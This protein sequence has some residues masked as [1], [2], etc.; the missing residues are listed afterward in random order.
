MPAYDNTAVAAKLDLAAD[1]LELAGA[2]KFRVLSYRKAAR[3]VRACPEQVA[4]LAS[5][6]ALTG[7]EGV[8]AKM[9]THIEQVIARGSFDALDE[10]SQQL[11]P[12]LAEVMHVSGVGPTRALQLHQ[13]LGVSSLDDLEDA[14]VRGRVA[15]LGGFGA[16][17]SE[18]IAESLATHRRHR[19][20]TPLAAALP[21]AE[22][23]LRDI[24]SLP[25]VSGA[26][27]AG[28]VRR[29]EETVGDIDLVVAAASPEVVLDAVAGISA[30]ERIAQREPGSLTLE[31]HDGMCVDV[32][33]VLPEQAAATLRYQTGSIEHN[34]Q[35][36]R[37]AAQAGVDIG[38]GAVAASEAAL[39]ASLGMQEPPPETRWGSGEI[40]AA[41]RH[42]IPVPI[43]L[44]EVLCDLQT[45]STFTDGRNTLAQNRAAAAQLGYEYFAATDHAYALRMVGGLSI[46]DL[47]RQWVE[48]DELNAEAAE[49]GLPR[50]LKGIELNIAP[51]GSLDYDDETLARFEIVLASL[52]S[53]W[54]EDEAT[55]T[56][57]VLRAIEHPLV[58]IVAHPTGRIIGRRDPIRVNVDAML[59]AAGETGTIME[60]NSYPD[61]LDLSAENIRKARKYGVRF[62]LGTDAH[63]SEQMRYMSYGV[64][65]AR[66]GL[67]TAAEL[68]NA[69]PWEV[70]ATWLK[71]NRI[72]GAEAL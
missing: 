68:L 11:P 31:L 5:E 48:I 53:G 23:L 71:R 4:A 70:A 59:E 3:A 32:S 52:H 63:A 51:D 24:G 57:R 10:L 58:D 17:T 18:K 27:I 69:H 1:L 22:A 28:G 42:E 2:D 40:E 47:E 15:A 72:A 44:A 61:R 21:Q 14:L 6:G 33:A 12:T 16:K 25:G 13:R 37:F 55:A 26:W 64:S 43:T 35:L 50:I 46:A 56:A 60:I 19:A 29:R 67:V 38:P 8:G 36:A 34:V 9:A 49:K 7:I 54:D 41:L 30:V 65:Q 66:R 39:Y 62:S 20:R 45:H